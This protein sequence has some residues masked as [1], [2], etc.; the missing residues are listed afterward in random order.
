MSF[1]LQVPMVTTFPTLSV[2]FTLTES[3]LASEG[4]WPSTEELEKR[5]GKSR[6]VLVITR[7]NFKQIMANIFDNKTVFATFV[8]RLLNF[9]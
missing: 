5:F 6:I 8:Q 4:S 1:L 3:R 2:I 7:I 9:W